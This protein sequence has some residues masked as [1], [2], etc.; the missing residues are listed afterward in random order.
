LGWRRSQLE[1]K[2]GNGR[3]KVGDGRVKVGD[4]RVKVGDGIVWSKIATL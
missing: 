2:M 1:E 4:G 3:V